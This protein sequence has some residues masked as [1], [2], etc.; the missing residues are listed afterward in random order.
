M[1]ITQAD[2][3]AMIVDHNAWLT[4]PALGKKLVI[5]NLDLSKAV[6]DNKNLTDAEMDGCYLHQA[7]FKNALMMNMVFTHNLCTE[8][9]FNSAVLDGS[10]LTDTVFWEADMRLA[11]KAGCTEVRTTY[12]D[13]LT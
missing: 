7:S 6:F 10:D 2:L 11:T 4:N 1:K 9:L 12:K 8:T 5:H 3:N 13:V